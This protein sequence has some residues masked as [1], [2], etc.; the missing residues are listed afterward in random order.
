MDKQ[1]RYDPTEIETE[2]ENKSLIFI[3]MLGSIS[4]LF[5]GM[6]LAYAYYIILYRIA[7]FQL[8]WIFYLNTLILISTSVLLY[9]GKDKEFSAYANMSKIALIMIISFFLLQ[10]VA[11]W[12]LFSQLHVTQN[13]QGIEFLYLLSIV[14]ALHVLAG[15]PFHVSYLRKVKLYT[16]VPQIRKEIFRYRLELMH[17]YWHFLDILW[18]CL[19]SIFILH[20]IT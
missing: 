17:R 12:Q 9:K 19:M 13:H 11:W 1:K 4:F 16:I 18:L 3:L 20:M 2:K 15:I 7:S 6:I 5:L 10:C 14:H 8:P